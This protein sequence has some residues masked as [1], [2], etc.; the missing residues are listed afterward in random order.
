M[1]CQRSCCLGTDPI[2]LLAITDAVHRT[3]VL[4]CGCCFGIFYKTQILLH[5]FWAQNLL[6]SVSQQS[7]EPDYLIFKGLRCP[8]FWAIILD[9]LSIHQRSD[10]CISYPKAPMGSEKLNTVEIT[11]SDCSFLVV[12]KTILFFS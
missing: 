9:I 2:G 4:S 10:S 6:P 8:I 7:E 3:V 1:S 5:A 12:N 11:S